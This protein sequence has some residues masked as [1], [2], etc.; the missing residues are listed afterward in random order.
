ML[1][2]AHSVEGPFQVQASIQQVTANPSSR[3]VMLCRFEEF[4]SRR[5]L[6]RGETM[7]NIDLDRHA[8][9]KGIPLL[10]IVLFGMAVAIAFF[11]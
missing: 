7:D 5:G 1:A 11:L 4:Y 3:Q 10:V 8:L 2:F 6:R 9:A